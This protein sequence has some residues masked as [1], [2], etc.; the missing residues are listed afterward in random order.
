MAQGNSPENGV[1]IVR[2]VSVLA[3]YFAHIIIR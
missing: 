1:S 3:G 2:K